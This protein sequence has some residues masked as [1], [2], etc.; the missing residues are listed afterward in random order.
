MKQ[1]E[2]VVFIQKMWYLFCN[3]CTQ[4]ADLKN[5]PPSYHVSS[6]ACKY[7]CWILYCL[8]STTSNTDPL[9]PD[10]SPSDTLQRIRSSPTACEFRYHWCHYLKFKPFSSN[11]ILCCSYL[12]KFPTQ[13]PVS[14]VAVVF[15]GQKS[16]QNVDGLMKAW[17]TEPPVFFSAGTFSL[18]LCPFL[19]PMLFYDS[20][21]YLFNMSC[22]NIFFLLDKIYP[23]KHHGGF[24]ITVFFNVC[25]VILCFYLISCI[26]H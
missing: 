8:P 7:I 15:F 14:G 23:L 6:D 21:P 1:W 5:P 17:I 16:L 10:K 13:T 11:A 26:L 25:R 19:I 18:L 24:G 4:K 12:V 9:A 22:L 2:Y 3:I 20:Y